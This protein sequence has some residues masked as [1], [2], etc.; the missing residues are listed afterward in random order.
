MGLLAFTD[1]MNRRVL[2]PQE[3]QRI[4]SLVPSITELL[5]SL[6]LGDRVVG[7]TRFCIFPEEA[8][9]NSRNIG[10]TKK[11]HIDRI[12]ELQPDL[13][14]GSKEENTR[15]E[16]EALANHHPVWM[17]DVQTV[18]QGID[19]I[20]QVGGITGTTAEA[21]LMADKIASGFKELKSA[22]Q[23]PTLGVAYLIWFDPIMVSGGENFINDVIETVGWQNIFGKQTHSRY[24]EVSIPDVKA[25]KPEVIF[26]SSEPYPFK[27]K[28]VDLFKE[29]LPGARV[30]LV[31]GDMFSW[32]GSRMLQMPAYLS[33]L[34]DELKS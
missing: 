33:K 23:Q 1:Q 6:G 34:A 29:A 10:G 32:Y 25:A 31:D 7:V 5:F 26:L 28:H 14:I 2:I 13:I 16:I 19:M 3:P 20:R 22:Q 30:L 27:Q 17:S 8:R 15:D 21:D 24:P 4:V 18:L 11:L 9:K 12:A